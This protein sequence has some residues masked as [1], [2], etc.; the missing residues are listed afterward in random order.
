MPV[1]T[2]VAECAWNVGYIYIIICHWGV[3]FFEDLP[4]V[5]FM[6]SVFTRM[7]GES[8]RRRLRSL[9]VYLYYVLRALI[10]SLVCWLRSCFS[11]WTFLCV[12]FIC[13]D[14]HTH[15][16][17]FCGLHAYITNDLQLGLVWLET[18]NSQ[19]YPS[20]GEWGSVASDQVLVCW[21]GLVWHF[22]FAHL[23]AKALNVTGIS[24]NCLPPPSPAS[25]NRL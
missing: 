14:H 9:L 23:V 2:C 3:S 20:H 15:F 5:E 1:H 10:N 6:Y 22:R 12:C 4:L 18:Q 13:C 21:F 7:P 16:W 25:S 19:K 8:Y 17:Q 11:L 24:G